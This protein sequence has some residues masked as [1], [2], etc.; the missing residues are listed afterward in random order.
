MGVAAVGQARRTIAVVDE[1]WSEEVRRLT[2]PLAE[3]QMALMRAVYDACL[4]D[5][6]WP[7]FAWVEAV[8]DQR[9]LD[10]LSVLADFPAVQLYPY[11]NYTAVAADL[12]GRPPSSNSEVFV[13][14]LG[15]W[16]LGQ[17]DPSLLESLLTPFY[18]VLDCV[19]GARSDFTPPRRED[20]LPEITWAEIREFL[21][22]SAH[23]IES[24]LLAILNADQPPGLLLPGT[25]QSLDTWRAR[26]SRQCQRFAGISGI[27]DY[28]TR[29]LVGRLVVS[30][31]PVPVVPSPL[32][33]AAAMDYLNTVWRLAYGERT[34]PFRFASA[35]RVARFAHEVGTGEEFFAAMS[36]VGDTISNLDVKD[37]SGSHPC[38]RLEARLTETLP[39]E[40][41]ARAV[42]AINVLRAAARIRH[43]GQHST[44]G[45]DVLGAWRDLGVGYPPADWGT[46]WNMIRGRLIEAIDGIREELSL[47]SERTSG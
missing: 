46:A 42:D 32:G 29:R 45:N 23:P 5:G 7:I 38:D 28:L 15:I 34:G 26:L 3:P 10:A 39:P 14:A 16:H 21:P 40:S 12:L 43:T 1:E 13:T 27:E 30:V 8:L 24:M 20:V 36:A 41:Q 17:N 44:V 35:E 22:Q 18:K 6:K 4:E 47:L 25:D 11:R 19:A 37:S 2:E 31:A 9:D 33:L